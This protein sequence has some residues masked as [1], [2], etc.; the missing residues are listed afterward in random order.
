MKNVHTN[1]ETVVL[2]AIMKVAKQPLA[3]YVYIHICICFGQDYVMPSPDARLSAAICHGCDD[4]SALHEPRS[5]HATCRV[6]IYPS[7][8]ICCDSY[9]LQCSA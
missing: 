6:Y 3:I 2:R 5:Q 9:P 7:N 1:M 4:Q 8:P